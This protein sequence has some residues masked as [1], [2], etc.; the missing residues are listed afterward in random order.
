MSSTKKN[1]ARK[2]GY[3]TDKRKRRRM[4]RNNARQ[5]LTQGGAFHSFSARGTTFHTVAMWHLTQAK[6]L[7]Y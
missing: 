5:L 7:S 6:Y 3:P 1:W 2:A 4:H